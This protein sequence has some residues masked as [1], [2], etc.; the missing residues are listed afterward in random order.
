MKQL[1]SELRPRS[2]ESFVG[3]SQ[4]MDLIK[5]N[6]SKNDFSHINIFYG[7][8]GTGKS[9]LAEYVALSL[10]CEG[11]EEGSYNPCCQCPI[12][13]S[14]IETNF[15]SVKG[16]KKV[17]MA[18]VDKKSI[19]DVLKEM[20]VFEGEA[21]KNIFILEE[22]QALDKDQQKTF[23]EYLAKVPEDV[24]IFITTDKFGTG[25]IPPLKNRSVVLEIKTP[26]F[27]E[28]LE[29]FDR[30]CSDLGI[31]VQSRTVARQFVKACNNNPRSIVTNL[32]LFKNLGEITDTGINSLFDLKENLANQMW[33]KLFSTEV[34]LSDF[35]SWC[36]ELSEK[37]S[38]LAVYNQLKWISVNNLIVDECVIEDDSLSTVEKGEIRKIIDNV[39][40]KTYESCLKI[41]E[42]D[43]R[44][45][46]HAL[47]VLTRC[48]I[49]CSVK[50]TKES[51]RVSNTKVA[52]M[53]GTSYAKRYGK[54]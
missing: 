46:D 34:T 45:D 16:I 4:V 3:N 40:L 51:E 48:K 14:A 44:D 49:N 13:K 6:L 9:S 28:A 21:K 24:Y 30:V 17:D 43:C 23:L 11:K 1:T 31:S 27:K 20:F 32:E 42:E 36:K 26:S 15:E 41:L 50:E 19:G 18:L 5:K 39:S 22:M 53:Q 35:I 29:F 25:I 38:I 54:I 8:N 2:L 10:S 37:D 7:R 47:S 33:K 52:S 12:C